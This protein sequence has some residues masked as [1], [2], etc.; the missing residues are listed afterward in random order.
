MKLHDA[1]GGLMV[2][3]LTNRGE[4]KQEFLDTYGD[5]QEKIE[6]LNFEAEDIIEL[7]KKFFSSISIQTESHM[8]SS[9]SSIPTLDGFN[10]TEPKYAKS[11][12]WGK[13]STEMS[14]MQVELLRKYHLWYGKSRL[15]IR[16]FLS[17]QLEPFDRSYK[18]GRKYIRLDCSPD[19]KSFHEFKQYFDIEQNILLLI[20]SVV[21][22][23][24]KI[25]KK[26][27]QEKSI[28]VGQRL[29]AE[30]IIKDWLENVEGDV[31][32]WLN[33]IDETTISYLNNLPR[34]SE[35]RIITSEIQNNNEFFKNASKFGRV[36]PKLEVKVIRVNSKISSNKEF[37][38]GERAIIHKRKL[39]YKSKMM[40]FGTDLK[41]SALGNTT[42]DMRLMEADKS[43]YKEFD[44]V[45][46][47]DES[48]WTRIEGIPIKV[49][50][51]KWPDE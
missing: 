27:F 5:A 2:S 40:D 41:S 49:T 15:L 37:S 46:N 30:R 42:H 33:Y 11:Y 10:N 34:D 17:D 22:D 13:L 23:G 48:E 19:T 12:S 26:I 36:Y 18:K 4:R 43:D 38:E 14:E 3:L 39:I 29:K 28:G 16:D 32:G 31:F 7:S 45:W 51:Y 20:S 9:G 25:N 6:R 21:E 1:Y 35:V 44:M 8:I 47:R 50:H 24:E